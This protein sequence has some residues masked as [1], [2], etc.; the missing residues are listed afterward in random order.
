ML[1]F[2]IALLTRSLWCPFLLTRRLN[3]WTAGVMQSNLRAD[4]DWRAKSG[5]DDA[6]A[7]LDKLHDEEVPGLT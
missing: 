2:S 1:G 4:A 3:Q 5:F 7:E 6:I